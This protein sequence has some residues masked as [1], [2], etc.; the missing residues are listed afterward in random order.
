MS[1]RTVLSSALFLL[2]GCGG[3]APPPAV[4]APTQATKQGE[5][6]EA[7]TTKGKLA[8]LLSQIP[9]AAPVLDALPVKARADLESL[10]KALGPEAKAQVLSVQGAEVRPLLHLA[11]GGSSPQAYLALGSTRRGADE[12]LGLQ[13]PEDAAGWKQLVEATREIGLRAAAQ[14][15][16][17]RGDDVKNRFTVELAEG[18][19][20]AATTLD[21]DDLRRLARR[22]AVEAEPTPTRWIAVVNAEAWML[23][24]DAAKQ[25]LAQVKAGD[26]ALADAIIGAKKSIARAERALKKPST[27]DEAID[28]A[29]AYLALGLTD[30][31]QKVLEPYRDKASSHLALSAT[32][33]VAEVG[34]GICP[35]LVG[36][37]ANELL[38]AHS[39]N[40]LA[41]AKKYTDLMKKAWTAGQGRD[42]QAMEAYI[43]LVYVVPWIYAAMISTGQDRAAL[44]ESFK[45]RIGELVVAS[46]DAVKVSPSF[47]GLS[48]FVD[49][50]AAALAAAERKGK[51]ERVVVKKETQDALLARARQLTK[52]RPNDR[53]TH[54]GV[55]A[56]AAMLAQEQDMLPLVDALPDDMNAHDRLIKQV[57]RVWSAVGAR[58][59][60][61][62]SDAAGDIAQLL[63]DE[64]SKPLERAKLVL[65]LAES[66]AAVTHDA[67]SQAILSKVASQ[68]LAEGVPAELRLR[69]VADRAGVLADQ[70][71]PGAAADLL[72]KVVS[73]AAPTIASTTDKDLFFVTRAYL[74]ALRGMSTKGDERVEYRDKL[75]ALLE[76]PDADEAPA[77]LDLFAKLWLRELSYQIE[78]ERCGTLKVCAD[79]A[80]TKRKMPEKEI[81]DRIGAQ[82]ATLLQHGVVPAGTLNLSFNF[83]ATSGL[84]PLV[85]F[86]P[87]ILALPAPAWA[88]K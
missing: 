65:I 69:A 88:L 16:R 60:P 78:V 34:G 73:T 64:K 47:E 87:R 74:F 9:P 32:L 51:D 67:R 31:A 1:F 61:L 68:L 71:D 23:H 11:L 82:S 46:K 26:P 76:S 63:P 40:G 62:A 48:L 66:E 4:K 7:K 3:A 19:D 50:L 79:R 24:V 35:R 72:E 75:Q 53:F 83:S 36:V 28:V 21:R 15:L 52:T 17:G 70:G 59:A 25:A 42:E 81:V 27:L 14:W 8:Q 77:S 58:K 49:T 86:E 56:V 84:E 44:A 18:I 5:E 43:G 6:P 38:C 33:A 12:L 10:S 13:L 45:R 22:A 85:G 41:A 20:H 29:R 57:L 2:V 37:V 55:L 30:E 80:A 39:W 54:A